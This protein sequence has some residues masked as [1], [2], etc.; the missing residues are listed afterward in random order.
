MNTALKKKTRKIEQ[1]RFQVLNDSMQMKSVKKTQF[2]GL[3]DKRYYLHDGIVS[4]PFGYYLSKNVREEKEKYR[5][6]LHLKIQK[7][8]YKFLA[9]ESRAVNLCERLRVLRSI[10]LNLRRCIS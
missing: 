7:E 6:E 9:L 10:M 5:S 4:F 8:M 3:Y 1:K 2:A